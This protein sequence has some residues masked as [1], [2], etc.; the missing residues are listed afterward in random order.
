M[1]VKKISCSDLQGVGRPIAAGCRAGC[2]AAIWPLGPRP[3][4][5]LFNRGFCIRVV[6]QSEGLRPEQRRRTAGQ[7]C[8]VSQPSWTVHGSGRTAATADTPTRPVARSFRAFAF[9]LLDLLRCL[10]CCSLSICADGE[11]L[12]DTE[13]K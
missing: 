10:G 9:M 12:A 5:T 4:D 6:L 8:L 13:E 2:A 7:P 3:R 1:G 11:S